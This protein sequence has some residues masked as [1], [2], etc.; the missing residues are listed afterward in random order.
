MFE[1]ASYSF[2]LLSI[3]TIVE[4]F[5]YMNLGFLML[6]TVGSGVEK[7][8][9]TQIPA[10]LKV[11]I[12]YLIYTMLLWWLYK[13]DNSK[14]SFSLVLV[15]FG[16]FVFYSLYFNQTLR[17]IDSILD[18]LKSW[19]KANISLVFI[20]LI[21]ITVWSGFLNERA[22][23]ILVFGN[24]DVYFWGLMSDHVIGI[25][26]L[27]IVEGRDQ[28][29]NQIIDCFGVYG[30]LGMMG[31]LCMKS[32]SI[33]AVM[34]FQLSISVLV[35]WLI[36]EISY[37]ILGVNRWASLVTALVFSFNPLWDYIFVNNFLSQMVA[38]FCFLSCI[39][40]VGLSE[41]FL[42]RDKKNIFIGF[43]VYTCF[44]FSYPGLLIPYLA[45]FLTS[46]V[47]FGGFL[48]R[49]TGLG[50][51]NNLMPK[52]FSIIVGFFIGAFVNY[53][54]TIHAVNRFFVLSEIAAGWKMSMLDPLNLIG[55]GSRSLDQTFFS[56][57]VTYFL[58]A[59]L[60]IFMFFMRIRNHKIPSIYEVRFNSLLFLSLV[61]LFA[62]MGVYYIKGDGYQHWKFATYFTLPLLIL[63]VVN[64]FAPKNYA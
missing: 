51:L 36:Y 40:I 48:C 17:S 10:V 42:G 30:W 62:Y 56:N 64:Y 29:L 26:N 25:T 32:H 46:V 52:L 15:V 6:G 33:E 49:S 61:S 31:R 43:I 44:V 8:G 34:L 14:L 57:W 39:Y 37:F 47:V 55:I 58:L 23:H 41:Y 60:L 11:L 1:P 20:E 12:G 24:N 22:Y 45:F 35:A 2:S 19:V 38:T 18:E 63:T 7:L 53:D 4:Y 27:K 13:T 21:L 50:F 5:L 3:Q 9:K 16:G 54:L 59:S 28:F